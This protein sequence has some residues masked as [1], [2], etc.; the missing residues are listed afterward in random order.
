M[1]SIVRNKGS[2]LIT[3][4]AISLSLSACVSTQ[5]SQRLDNNL[6]A[7]QNVYKYG[8]ARIVDDEIHLIST[9]NWFL[10]SKQKYKDFILEAEIKMPD[11]KEYSNSGIIFRAD[12]AYNEK[13][14]SNYAFG[15]QAEVDPSDRKWSG[16]LY[17]QGTKRQW[18]HPLHDKRSAPDADFKQNITKQWDETK[19]NAYKHLEW[20]KYKIQA[21]GSEI[22]I[23]VNNVLTT[24]V[25]DEKTAEG[26]IG[27]Q[28]HGSWAFKKNGDRTNTVKFRNIQITEI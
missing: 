17:E 22:K 7:W 12:V 14:K 3:A 8:E 23:W 20:N 16:G 9:G 15:Y 24:H 19:A 2:Q 6:D 26:F 28:H 11:V 4:L 1:F 10:L 5:S 18:L 25:I 13:K 27:I 21:K